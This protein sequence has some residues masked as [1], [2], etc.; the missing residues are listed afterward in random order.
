MATTASPYGF[1]PVKNADGSPYNG[2][3]NSYL[4]DPA[5]VALNMGY[6]SIVILKDGYVQ[7]SVKTGSASGDANNFSAVAN[8]G[9]LGVFVGCE[10]VNAQ[11][12]LV[13]DQLYPSGYAAPAGT[14]IRAYVV[15]DPNVTFQVQASG[16][17]AQAFLGRNTFLSA[18][19]DGDDGDVNLTTGKSKTAVS[20]SATDA[21]AAFKIMGFSDRPGST[22]GDTYTDLLVKFNGDYHQYAN[23]DVTS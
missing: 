19:P 20:H 4:I 23:A 9:A 5:G 7:L 16:A 8:G 21:T 2:A 13:F 1:I 22:V 10:Y 12:Q 6:G 17:V 14:E 18:T 3:R 11:G 15:D